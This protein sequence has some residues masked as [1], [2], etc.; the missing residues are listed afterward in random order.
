[1]NEHLVKL[2]NRT[3]E[4]IDRGDMLVGHASEFGG[5]LELYSRLMQIPVVVLDGRVLL[6]LKDPRLA[7]NRNGDTIKIV[8]FYD[9]VYYS[10]GGQKYK[11]KD[12][13]W[14]VDKELP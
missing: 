6:K 10:G 14:I 5:D 12:I 7:L 3:R 9:G 4:A 13:S 8:A 2:I 11:E 1:M